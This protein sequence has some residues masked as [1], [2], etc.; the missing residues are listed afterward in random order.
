MTDPA[1]DPIVPP[2]MI[3]RFLERWPNGDGPPGP[4]RRVQDWL[5]TSDGQAYTA[6][7]NVNV[8]IK[9]MGL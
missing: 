7:Q 9:A 1:P 6:S 2:P 5:A 3:A 4:M 8:L